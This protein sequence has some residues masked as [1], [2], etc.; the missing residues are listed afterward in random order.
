[1]CGHRVAH[2]PVGTDMLVAANTRL[3]DKKRGNR[4]ASDGFGIHVHSELNI[5]M[6]F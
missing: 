4:P 3:Q 5:G 2:V 1:M 6:R